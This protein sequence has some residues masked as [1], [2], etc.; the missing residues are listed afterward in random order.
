MTRRRHAAKPVVL[1]LFK[2]GDRGHLIIEASEAVYDGG[3][4]SRVQ[5]ALGNR[6]RGA[7]FEIE[8]TT[9][10]AVRVARALNTAASVV[11][12]LN[13]LAESERSG[14]D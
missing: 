11:D 14:T 3:T 7:R 13:S 6:E 9:D 10:E 2:P 1:R 12:A 4:P 8:L 5:L